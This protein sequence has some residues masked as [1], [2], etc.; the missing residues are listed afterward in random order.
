[1]L[2]GR[3]LVAT[4][5]QSANTATTFSPGAGNTGQST[6]IVLPTKPDTTLE[7]ATYFLGF[8]RKRQRESDQHKI[9]QPQTILPIGQDAATPPV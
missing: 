8:G 2:M 4:L 5:L 1:M 9:P 6:P 3:Q 7:P